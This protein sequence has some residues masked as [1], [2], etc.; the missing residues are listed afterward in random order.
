MYMGKMYSLE[1]VRKIVEKFMPYFGEYVHIGTGRYEEPDL[2]DPVDIY[3]LF[4]GIA[5]TAEATYEY[6]RSERS[7]EELKVMLQHIASTLNACECV[8]DCVDVKL[9]FTKEGYINTLKYLTKQSF[10]QMRKYSAEEGVSEAELMRLEQKSELM[11]E[12]VFEDSMAYMEDI[13]WVKRSPS[14]YKVK[15]KKVIV[16]GALWK[17][18]LAKG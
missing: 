13:G 3:N 15:N 2:E 12:K 10:E 16:A 4:Q 18:A 1:E 5:Y 9:C 7:I 6:T 14:H 11:A 8:A 17:E